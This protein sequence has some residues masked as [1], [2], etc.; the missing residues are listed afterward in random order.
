MM[1]PPWLKVKLPG[2]G[3]YY[4]VRQR[5]K[6]IGVHTVCEEA[7]CPNAAEC[8]GGGT[9]TFM[10]LGDVCTRGCRFC[11]VT[12]GHPASPPAADEPEK[13]AEAALTLGLRY[14]V[15]TSVD[16][17][18]LCDGGANHFC[19]TVSAVRRRIPGVIVEILTPDFRGDT[20]TLALV[21]HSGA[22][23]IGHNVETT[24]ELTPSIRDRRCNYDLSL[25]VL[26]NLHALNPQLI[27]KSSILLGL[28]ETSD[29][30]LQCLRDLRENGVDWVTL[31]QYLQ[32]TR[33]HVPVQQYVEPDQFQWFE[34]QA[35][36][37]GFP[38]VT[39]G[40][41]VRSS[42]RAAEEYAEVLIKQRQGVG[43]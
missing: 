20:D 23:V 17:D 11:A 15:I 30:V 3:Q 36:E 6:Q 28:G 21:A 25:Q 38:L 2:N 13:I 35:R 19:L 40:P 37:M 18:D 1:R 5:L 41:L 9:A 16:R 12:S 31:G 24:R 7:R 42:Y 33:K 29:S 39:S 27:T 8:W 32:P 43:H 26:K 14:V 34:Q 4:D 10:I 22:Q